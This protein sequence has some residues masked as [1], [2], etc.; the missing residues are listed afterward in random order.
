MSSKRAGKKVD[1]YIIAE[2]IVAICKN[3]LEISRGRVIMKEQQNVFKKREEF[4]MKKKFLAYILTLCMVAGAA[5][6]T[7]LADESLPGGG[8]FS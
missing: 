6:M 4:A 5:P 1:G 7:V 3:G 8:R 2:K